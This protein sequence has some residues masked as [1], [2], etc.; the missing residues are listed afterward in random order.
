MEA[1]FGSE[2]RFLKQ[3]IVRK[4][5]P[6]FPHDALDTAV[7]PVGRAFPSADED[8]ALL[9]AS[10]KQRSYRP[11]MPLMESVTSSIGLMPSTVFKAPFP[12]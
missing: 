9:R 2:A 12:A 11:R 8:L 1:T 7:L 3:R 10:A 4:T 6:T 5:G